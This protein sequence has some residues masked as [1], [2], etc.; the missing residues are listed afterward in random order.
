[1]VVFSSQMT[2]PFFEEKAECLY[3]GINEVPKCNQKGVERDIED[4]SYPNN[5]EINAKKIDTE[6][7][8]QFDVDIKF[9]KEYKKLQRQSCRQLARE[10][11]FDQICTRDEEVKILEWLFLE[12]HA[13][14][15][16]D[17]VT[18]CE[19]SGG[20]LYSNFDGSRE[21]LSILDEFVGNTSMII[22]L[23]A[24]Y[25]SGKW[26]TF[27]MTEIPQHVMDLYLDPTEILPTDK[28][29]LA[30]QHGD[31]VEL[32]VFTSAHAL[33]DMLSPV[34]TR[35]T[36]EPNFHPLTTTPDY[37]YMKNDTR[38]SVATNVNGL[39]F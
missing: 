33:C 13:L 11:N 32:D 15:F 17:A 29:A 3:M 19:M 7:K 28:S 18:V 14:P 39:K 8:P 38:S 12:P 36:T 6:V 27:R 4:D 1:M 22:W 5:C 30:V 23:G 26:M 24:K 16:K 37:I 25:T 35:N 20:S 2:S 10:G 31:F 9:G 34:V 21:L